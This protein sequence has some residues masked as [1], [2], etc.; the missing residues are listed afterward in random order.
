LSNDR[1]LVDQVVRFAQDVSIYSNRSKPEIME[2]FYDSALRY[3]N[4]K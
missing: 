1:T 2:S 4:E 3:A